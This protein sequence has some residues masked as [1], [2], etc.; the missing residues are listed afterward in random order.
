M[1]KVISLILAFLLCLSLSACSEE[2]SDIKVTNNEVTNN[3]VKASNALV[4]T[5]YSDS[6][7]IVINFSETG[8]INC[9]Y[10]ECNDNDNPSIQRLHQSYTL[11]EDNRLETYSQDDTQ[12]G[13]YDWKV[14]GDILILLEIPSNY[15]IILQ[16]VNRSEQSA[17]L[18]VGRWKLL[19]MGHIDSPSYQYWE[20]DVTFYSDGSFVSKHI[21][22]YNEE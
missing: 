1:K 6:D 17:N 13:T 14:D 8:K 2:G 18:L 20:Y 5:W 10:A 11:K 3:E 22:Y 7:G 16:K 15:E 19:S 12:T 21:D 9:Y 4:G